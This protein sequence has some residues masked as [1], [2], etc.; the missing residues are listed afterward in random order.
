MIHHTGSREFSFLLNP[1]F[2]N[3]IISIRIGW[4]VPTTHPCNCTHLSMIYHTGWRE[5]SF[6]LNPSFT[7]TTIDIDI[8]WR[9]PTPHPCNRT[10]F[11]FIMWN[12]PSKHTQFVF[13]RNYETL[14]PDNIKVIANKINIHGHTYS[15]AHKLIWQL[16]W[17]IVLQTDGQPITSVDKMTPS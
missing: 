11:V 4:R 12:D 13:R 17:F 3:T 15:T 7:N 2:T 9:A 14:T 8:R 16:H 1:S 5:F 6:L 10:H